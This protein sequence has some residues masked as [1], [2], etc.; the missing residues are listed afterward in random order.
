MLRN[1]GTNE[2]FGGK[3]ILMKKGKLLSG[4]GIFLADDHSKEER[5]RRMLVS[6]MK[7]ART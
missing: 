4:S 7:K 6:E 1:P 2:K 5:R 3:L